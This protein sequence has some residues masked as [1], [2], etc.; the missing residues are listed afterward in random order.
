MKK[1]SKGR[2]RK[3]ADSMQPWQFGRAGRAMA[4]YDEAREKGEK[5]SA[6]VRYA[7]DSLRRISPKLRISETEVKRILSKFRPRGSGTIVRFE[8]SP[9][10]EEDAKKYRWIREQVAALKKQKGI[11]LQQTPVYDETRPRAKVT[12]RFSKRPNYPRH[13]RKTPNK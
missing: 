6:A 12:F 2:P 4:A 10:T 8:R 11:I 3:V 7:V 1:K 9:F 5:H 13:N